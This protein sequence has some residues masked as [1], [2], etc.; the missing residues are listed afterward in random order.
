ERDRRFSFL[1]VVQPRDET[2]ARDATAARAP[3]ASF[4][5]EVDERRLVGEAGFFEFPYIDYRWQP[6]PGQAYGEGPVMLALADIKTLNAMSKTALRAGQQAVDPPLAVADDG[7][8]NRPNLNARAINY[9]A[10]DQNGRLRI[11]PIITAQ[12]PDFAQAI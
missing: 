10:I 12:R 11:Q 6:Q 3:F 5:V 9:G 1:H 7:V 2:G 4:H 8:T